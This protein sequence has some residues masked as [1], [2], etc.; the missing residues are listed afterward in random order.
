MSS[1]RRSTV[2]TRGASVLI[3]NLYPTNHL[4]ILTPTNPLRRACVAISTSPTFETLIMLAIAV[5]CVIMALNTPLPNG[6]KSN[7]NIKLYKFEIYFLGIFITEACLK[8]VSQG[9]I[10]HPHSYLRIPWNILDFIV[11]ITGILPFAGVTGG[12]TKVIKA[13][14][15]LRP[16]KIVSKFPSLQLV[17]SAI[18]KSMKSLMEIFFLLG[19]IIIIY[20]IV[21]MSLF[22]GLFHQTCVH[23]SNNTVWRAE[24]L[25]GTNTSGGRQCPEGTECKQFWSGPNSGITSFDNIFLSCIT[26]FQCITGQ[27]WTDIMYA[28][29]KVYE[30]K[31]YF[32]WAYFY[33]LYIVG[34]HFML[35]LVCAVLTGEF[36]KENRRVKNRDEF[37]IQRA[38]LAAE[39]VAEKYEAWVEEGEVVVAKE[40][41]EN[42]KKQEQSNGKP[43]SLIVRSNALRANIKAVMLSNFM[44][45]VLIVLV[46]LNSITGV[47]QFYQQQQ[48]INDL[49]NI[50]DNFF[51]IFFF[52]ETSLKLYAL[53]PS[54]YFQSKFNIFD[55]VVVL[56]SIINWFLNK[57]MNINLAVSVLRQLR[58]MRL[59]KF[60]KLWSSLKNLINSI[61]NSMVS[62]ISLVVLLLLFVM[63]FGLLGIQL[64]SGLYKTNLRSNFDDF[65]NAML[66]V[67]QIVTGADWY[68]LLHEGI[69]AYGGALNVIGVAVSIYYILILVLGNFVIVNVFLAIAVDNISLTADEKKDIVQEELNREEK[70]KEVHDKFAPNDK[71][72]T[73]TNG[74]K[75]NKEEAEETLEDTENNLDEFASPKNVCTAEV[76][77][78]KITS[79]PQILQQNTFFIFAPTNPM[80]KAIHRLISSQMFENAIFALIIISSASLACEDVTDPNAPINIILGYIDYG[81]TSI[82]TLEALLKIINFGVILHANAYFRRVW[83]CVDSFVVVCAITS[84]VL[85]M[86]ANKS[87]TI[88]TI[89]KV[90]R[91]LRVIRPLKIIGRIP[92][93]QA[94]FVCLVLSLKNVIM[95]LI[96]LIQLWLIFSIMGVQL[97]SGLFWYCTDE[98]K[99]NEEDCVGSF[100]TFDGNN[101]NSPI[102]RQRNWLAYTFNFDNTLS[103]FITLFTASLGSGWYIHMHHGIDSTL[104]G[105]SPLKNNKIWASVYFVVYIIVFM[106]FFINVFVGLIILT[107]QKLAAAEFGLELDRNKKNSFIFAMSSRPMDRYIPKNVNGLQYKAW[108][109]IESYPWEMFITFLIILNIISMLI[110]YNNEP[111]AFNNIMNV[112]SFG[113][114][115]VFIFEFAVKLFALSFNLFKVFWNVFDALIVLSGLLDIMIK[116][117]FPNISFDTSI[118]RLFRA[119]RLI[120]LLR[121]VRSLRILLWTFIKSLQALPHVVMLIFLLFFVYAFVGMQIF[122]QISIEP[123]D[124]PWG[125]INENNHF[126]TYFSSM[127]VLVR[128]TSGENWPLIMKACSDGARCDYSMKAV[129]P[130]STQCGTNFAYVYFISFIF[131]CCYLVLNLF[132]AV[133]MDNFSFL[134]GDSSI[135]GPHHLDEFVTVWSDFDPCASGRI[136][137]TEVCE[138]LR[139]MQPPLG[140]GAKCPNVLAYKRLVQMNMILYENGTV[141]YTGTFCALVRTGLEVYTENTNLKSNDMEFR[142]MLKM[143]FPN[144]T[145]R[146]LDLVI[147]RTPKNCKEMTIAKIYSAKLIWEHYKSIKRRSNRKR[148]VHRVNPLPPLSLGLRIIKYLF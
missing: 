96:I 13:A 55:F 3:E 91:I 22:Q 104:Q 33:S 1:R 65:F 122:S 110:E 4:L 82:F 18:L 47:M 50:T 148:K 146:T 40:L 114:T 15:V 8:I 87:K 17:L 68:M 83:N 45:W 39:R 42:S 21:G 16:L 147:P 58:L 134:T 60:T 132:V 36:S 20:A 101:Y 138:L 53:G 81:F 10:L 103:A 100:I 88:K 67:F 89:I 113:F 26:V 123:A 95:V 77:D 27:G 131:F 57:F 112:V 92:K 41:E 76:G 6:D 126:R 115:I 14:K 19:F 44:Y 129:D 90:L 59:I 37:L 72:L 133:I 79:Q 70:L 23:K 2:T 5:N 34:T 51:L 94:V 48:W 9:F 63:I 11:I 66:S 142:K 86:K 69:N 135:L 98:S 78:E 61:L 24:W 73:P 125:Q 121:K 116:A 35:N 28:L 43:S 31:A 105:K 120:K 111:Q 102:E 144:I 84:I 30:E 117:L 119:L 85:G 106:L 118:F 62:I 12:P 108:V 130:S 136:K 143:E 80:R 124:N 49:T 52:L 54:L 38:E 93:L 71:N 46:I 109:L 56:V 75:E 107:F 139:Q 64:F 140:L 99:D 141:D 74:N 145:K 32:A 128:S 97:F 25:C 7:L 137:Y 29:F 127:Q